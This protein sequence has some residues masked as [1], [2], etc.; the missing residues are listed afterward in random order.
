MRSDTLV[1]YD[2]KSRSH[3]G[4]PSGIFKVEAILNN[5]K[6]GRSCGGGGGGGGGGSLKLGG[7]KVN[8]GRGRSDAQRFCNRLAGRRGS[9]PATAY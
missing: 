2:G 5:L 7:L 9:R 3:E 6:V 4:P 1:H 8:R